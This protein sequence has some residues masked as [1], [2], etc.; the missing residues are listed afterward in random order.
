MKTRLPPKITMPHGKLWSGPFSNTKRL[1]AKSLFTKKTWIRVAAA[2]AIITGI[3]ITSK[4]IFFPKQQTNPIANNQIKIPDV[5]PASN[6]ATLILSTGQQ[7]ILDSAKNGQLAKFGNTTIT[8]TDSGKLLYAVTGAKSSPD[9]TSFNELTTPRG[10]IYELELPDGSEAWL[11]AA[12]RIDYP[13]R[14]T[15]KNREVFIE[16]EVYFEVAHD[17]AHPFVVSLPAKTKDQGERGHW[18]QI[19]VLGTHFNVNTY[20]EITKTTLL[21]GSIK[22]TAHGTSKTIKPEEQAISG[23]NGKGIEIDKS[24]DLD[25]VMAWRNGKIAITDVSVQQLMSEISRWYDMDVE[26]KGAVPEKQFYGTIR[27][28]V[29][30]S[31]VL[32]ALKTYGVETQVEGKKIIVQ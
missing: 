30:L 13:T 26:Y 20:S 21:E 4:F 8:K 3:F 12:S 1:S 10:G 25:K 18:L 17:A 14:F 28:D 24:V 16:G 22:I 7:I 32:N 2:A 31:T 6:K 27:R 19:E 9:E 29:P 23:F 5:A 11:N 15:G